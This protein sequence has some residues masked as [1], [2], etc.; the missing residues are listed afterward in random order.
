VSILDTLFELPVLTLDVSL[1]LPHEAGGVVSGFSDM[2]A[3]SKWSPVG[4]WN[5]V[6]G[7]GEDGYDVGGKHGLLP[8]WMGKGL[9]PSKIPAHRVVCCVSQNW[10]I[11]LC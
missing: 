4:R 9:S 3:K 1:E 11:S 6:D 2:E 8:L 7:C 5:T 10:T